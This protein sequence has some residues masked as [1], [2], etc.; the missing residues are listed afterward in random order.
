M[1]TRQIIINGAAYTVCDNGIVFGKQG[2][3]SQRPNSDGYATFTAGKKGNRARIRTHR[4]VAELF[5]PNPHG[6]PEVD[7]KDANRM[8]PSADNLEWVTRKENVQRA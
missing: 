2:L 6:Y 8:N 1:N 5:V 7:H 3:I 4:I